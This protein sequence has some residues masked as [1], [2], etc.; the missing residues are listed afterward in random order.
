M[1]YC[2]IQDAWGK[3][4]YISNQFKSFNT[5]NGM[6]NQFNNSN[7]NSNCNNNQC[8]RPK[9]RIEPETFTNSNTYDLNYQSTNSNISSN[10]LC[11]AVLKHIEDCQSCKEKI[12]SKYNLNNENKKNVI[13]HF[14]S[15]LID[16]FKHT[17]D[18]NKDTVLLVLIGLFILIFINLLQSNS[19]SN[20]KK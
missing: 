12:M 2:S 10:D 16:N 13:E 18:G 20:D 3:G 8:G 14:S 17:I 6:N 5:N 4:D 9:P 11:E 7:N 19:S 15:T 1:N